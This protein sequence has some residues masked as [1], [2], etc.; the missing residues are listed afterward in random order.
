M[1]KLPDKLQEFIVQPNLNTPF[2]VVDLDRVLENYRILTTNLPVVKCFYSVKSNPAPQ[3][4]KT[5]LAKGSNFEAASVGEIELCLSVGVQAKNIHFG[6]T[7]KSVSS[8]KKSFSYG[9]RS[10]AFDCEEELLKLHEHAP[11]ASVTC[12]IAT[13]GEGATWGL[14]RKFGCSA[15]HAGDLLAQAKSLG[16]GKLGLSFHVGSQQKSPLAWHR[17]LSDTKTI[18]DEL[19]SDKVH[20]TTIN[21]GGGFPASGYLDDNNVPISYDV[22]QYCQEI[23]AYINQ[24]FGPE[25]KYN[26]MCEPGRFLLSEAGCI[27]TE[28]ILATHKT[29]N[30]QQQKWLYL[31]VGK[32]NG[33]YE[34]TDIKHPIYCAHNI[35]DELM[36]TTLAGPSC[37]SDDMLS[38][39][40]DLHK[41]PKTLKTG[42]HIAF[43]STGAYSNSY[44]SVGFNGIPP[45]TEY[46]I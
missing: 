29:I 23:S 7:I 36:D 19:S 35:S 39:K 26:F 3:V 8:I 5:L 17:A 42:D 38:Y 10:F 32:F 4:I 20:L 31:D 13:T 18:I 12:R 27:K 45:L 11:G 37:D 24:I 6:N 41:L 28:V 9:I 44:L 33:L 25:H 34:G 43:M 30:E 1:M 22:A 40:E 15:S 2:L 46:Y 16:M 21:I 14:C